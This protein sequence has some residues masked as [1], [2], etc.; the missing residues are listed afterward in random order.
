[1]PR[2]LLSA[3]LLLLS[4]LPALAQEQQPPLTAHL[5]VV[6]DYTVR[7]ISRSD[8][9]PAVQGGVQYT[10]QSGFYAGADASTVDMNLDDDANVEAVLFGGATGDYSGIQYKANLSYNAYPGGDNDDLDYWEFE[11]TGGYDFGPFSGSLT[12]AISPDYI[13]DSG[14]SLYYGAD[15]EAP[16][17]V[18]YTALTAKAHLGFQ[19][20]DDEQNYAQDYADWSLGL[21]Y[22]WE[23]YDIDFGLQYID[24]D[25]DDDECAEDCGSRAVLSAAKSFGW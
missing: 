20:I 19:F 2:L 18:G 14:V 8:E 16:I 12:W 4:A 17:P 13:N 22:N 7:G 5:G 9:G 15:L 25:L 21:W 11:L 10:H 1:M 23:P 24:T 6:S 3:S